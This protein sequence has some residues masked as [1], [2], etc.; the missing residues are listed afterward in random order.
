MVQVAKHCM[1]SV[2]NIFLHIN[3][4]HERTTIVIEL[5]RNVMYGSLF[6]WEV[7]L[8]EWWSLPDVLRRHVG[9]IFKGQKS[10]KN[11]H[12]LPLNMRQCYLKL[13]A[14][15]IQWHGNTTQNRDLNCITVETHKQSA[16]RAWG[17]YCWQKVWPLARMK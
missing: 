11:G 7:M 2:R 1:L 10:M 16:V 9:H 15:V 12:F 17:S 13:Q 6:F 14:P 5:L 3:P 4:V 8:H